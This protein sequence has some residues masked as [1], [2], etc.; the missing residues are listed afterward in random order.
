MHFCHFFKSEEENAALF[1]IFRVQDFDPSASLRE[2]V[3]RTK[4]GRRNAG[5]VIHFMNCNE[6]KRVL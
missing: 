4:R 5:F 2:M 3:A 1:C 6:G